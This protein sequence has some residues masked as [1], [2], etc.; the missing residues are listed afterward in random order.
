MSILLDA[1]TRNKQQQQSPLPDAVMTPRANYPQP[2][3]SGVPIGKLS[4]LVV[5]VAAGI[6]VAWGLSV[7]DKTRPPQ[8][9]TVAVA[10]VLPSISSL[11]AST[12]IKNELQSTVGAASELQV[13][14]SAASGVRLAGKVALPR[15]Q[16]L[17]ELTVSPQFQAE[18][19]VSNAPQM[20]ASANITTNSV[21][22][23]AQSDSNSGFSD[24]SYADYM[25]TSAQV[26]AA[27]QEAVVPAE[28]QAQ[29]PMMLGAN[30]NES[31]L[32]S[33]EALRQQVSAAAEDVGL[34]TNKSR[35]ED[36]LVAS[37]QNAL[38]DVEYVNAAETNI[39][40]AK[41]DPIPKTAVDE[42]PK[43][44]QLPAGLQLQVPEFNIVAHVYSS[45][46][47]QRWLN[48]DGAELQEG[49]MIAGKLKII[50]IRPRD[51]VLDIQGTQFKV[52]A[53]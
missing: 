53:I 37:F 15:T 33:L 34:E 5:A 52:P 51:I 35:D 17:P 26:D 21:G 14:P 41:L 23:P 50:S 25:S 36:K 7:W 1:V 32:A 42:I 3:K 28:T 13:E 22:M 40:E 29:Q 6:G 24:S 12:A 49:D 19:V 38:K 2:R 30:A 47:A 20:N 46:P 4:I 27:I 18:T 45:D 48:V 44:G 31:G 43:Y 9:D 10:N 16:T 11:P 39:T 8:S